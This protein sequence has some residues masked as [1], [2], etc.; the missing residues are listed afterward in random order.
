M[1][2]HQAALRPTGRRQAVVDLEV[3]D[4]GDGDRGG[5]WLVTS[6]TGEGGYAAELAEAESGRLKGSTKVTWFDSKWLHNKFLFHLW[7]RH[8][9]D[10]KPLLKY[11]KY[12]VFISELL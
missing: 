12:L 10:G 1:L 8:K 7:G 4:E 2:P 9:E 3:L 11:W 5:V 6:G